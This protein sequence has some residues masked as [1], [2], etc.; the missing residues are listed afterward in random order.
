[1]TYPERIERCPGCFRRLTDKEEKVWVPLKR[2]LIF[3][4]D[5]AKDLEKLYGID[6]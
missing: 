6:L 5:C 1:M 4:M 2:N 3:C